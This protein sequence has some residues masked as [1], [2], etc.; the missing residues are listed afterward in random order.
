MALRRLD[1]CVAAQLSITR[2]HARSLIMEGRVRVD[3]LTMTKGG[4]HVR[5]GAAVDITSPRRYVS[6]G[7]EKLAAA[8]AA[9]ELD[10]SGMTALDVGAST[11]GFTDCLLQAGAE[12]VVA[13]DV[14]YGQ[15]DWSLRTNPHVEVR[16]RTNV[17]LLP[18]DAF[19]EGFDLVVIDASFISLRSVIPNIVPFL[20]VDARIIAL[21]KPQFEA[22]R[23]RI[24]K[25][26]VVR[27][28]EVHMTV[29]REVRSMIANLGLSMT[30][31]LASPLRGPAGNRE[32]LVR[33]ERSGNAVDDAL[34]DAVV[35]GE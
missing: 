2:S 11:G 22:G 17:R 21:V 34:I 28:P 16:E 18:V 30:A 29:V 14:G 13:L 20:R 26:G 33:I 5:L 4:Q 6:R 12:R 10:V 24:G 32:F 3:G 31:L 8:L 19:P 27:D 1:D 9:F 15:L 7:G 35:A 25:G 23:D